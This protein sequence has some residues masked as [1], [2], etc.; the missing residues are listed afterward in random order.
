MKDNIETKSLH[1]PEWIVH[2]ISF[3]ENYIIKGDNL[4]NSVLEN[5]ETI[6]KDIYKNKTKKRKLL[7]I[8]CEFVPTILAGRGGFEVKLLIRTKD[9]ENKDKLETKIIWLEKNFTDKV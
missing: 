4:V 2:S 1:H 6:E 8:E 9:E 3:N 7:K 5:F